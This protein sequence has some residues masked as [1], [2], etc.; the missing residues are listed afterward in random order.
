MNKEEITKEDIL[1]VTGS[2]F[3]TML[4]YVDNSNKELEECINNIKKDIFSFIKNFSSIFIS[5]FIKMEDITK[6]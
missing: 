2:V 1:N 6:N 5:I 4:D 3:D